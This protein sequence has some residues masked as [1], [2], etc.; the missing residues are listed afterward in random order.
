MLRSAGRRLYSSEMLS[1]GSSDDTLAFPWIGWMT[2]KLWFPLKGKQATWTKENWKIWM[3]HWCLSFLA[4]FL[5]SQNVRY[6][7]LLPSCARWFKIQDSLLPGLT[8]TMECIHKKTISKSKYTSTIK[9]EW[10]HLT[11]VWLCPCP[12]NPNLK[13]KSSNTA[14][15]WHTA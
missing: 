12:N 7:F 11:F 3:W 4:L 15:L 8:R 9:S 1:L 13:S 6:Q 14:P 10:G 5:W 2:R